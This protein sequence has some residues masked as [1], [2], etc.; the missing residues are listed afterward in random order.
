M[1][2]LWEFLKRPG[3]NVIVSFLQKPGMEGELKSSGNKKHTE[4]SGDS[5]LIR[6]LLMLLYKHLYLEMEKSLYNMLMLAFG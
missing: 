6:E 1:N 2:P 5:L 4:V 3:A